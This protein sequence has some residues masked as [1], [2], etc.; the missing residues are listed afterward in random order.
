MIEQL[1][2]KFEFKA[3]L[4]HDTEEKVII[5]GAC[6]INAGNKVIV[7]CSPTQSPGGEIR[8]FAAV[9]EWLRV[10]TDLY[11]IYDPV[12]GDYTIRFTNGSKIVFSPYIIPERTTVISIIKLP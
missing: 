8:N 7:K 11:Q 2:G 10:D 1:T 9:L 6:L 5:I 4:V 12:Y 3:Y